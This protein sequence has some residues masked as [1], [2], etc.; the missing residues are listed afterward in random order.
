VAG[1]E[2][3]LQGGCSRDRGWVAG[4]GRDW[5]GWSGAG[6][7]SRE[8]IGVVGGADMSREEGPWEL[9]HEEGKDSQGHTLPY[10]TTHRAIE[11]ILSLS[12]QQLSMQHLIGSCVSWTLPAP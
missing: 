1:G 11:G 4:D 2:A 12:F 7:T 8:R 9:S 10:R 5:R 3:A 6:K